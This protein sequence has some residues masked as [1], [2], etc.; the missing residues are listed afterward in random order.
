MRLSGRDQLVIL[1]GG[2]V[3]VAAGVEGPLYHPKSFIRSLPA[4][5]RERL[6]GLGHAMHVVLLLN[7]CAT[8]IGR[9]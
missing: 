7:G 3:L 8:A 2:S 9:V 5:V 6:V 1:S 4:V